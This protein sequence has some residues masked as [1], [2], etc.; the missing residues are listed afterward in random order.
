M[1]QDRHGILLGAG[2]VFAALLCSFA[3]SAHA[4][5]DNQEAPAQ[6]VQ[7]LC[8]Q[9]HALEVAGKCLAG[10]CAGSRVVRVTKPR[11]WN[12]VLDK[13]VDKGVNVSKK[14]RRE[15]LG[16]LQANYPAMSYPLSWERIN[17]F[18]GQ[19]G[20]NVNT[21]REYKGFLYAGFEG[22][23]KIFR[24]A[25]GSNW[26]EVVSTHQD[27]VYGITPFQGILYAG[28]A[29][30]TPQVWRSSD[31]LH[32]QPSAS[33]PS[34]DVGI[35]SVG[36]FKDQL[37]VGTGRSWI[38]RSGDG[39]K[40]EKVAAL[41]GDIHALFSHWV[42]FLVPFNGTLY[43]GLEQGPLYRSEDGLTWVEV[44]S[45]VSDG[46][47]ARGA[48]V[49]N[50]AL[51]V[52]A[53]SGGDIWKTEDGQNWQHVFKVPNDIPGYVASMAVA[54]NYLFASIN[55]YVFRT[56]DGL[57]WEEVGHLASTTLEAMAAWRGTLYVGASI[58]PS[59]Y[60]YRT[61]ITQK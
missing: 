6:A 59:A 41:K 3:P 37:Y 28:A 1:K 56:P 16:F 4:R 18:T 36:V 12:M 52:G 47:G 14:E 58:S 27:T 23:G 42:R 30:P 53:T 24:S 57:A 9:C 35:Y 8:S 10:D 50:G 43:A 61:S 20:W 45:G 33:L 21:L 11:P 5:P 40:W 32:W 39:Q 31:G 49:F 17:A 25:D 29:E 51:Y 2:V 48:M 26:Q 19:G 38:Y 34:E 22:N 15:I 55:G 7:R 46:N 13:M 44:K 60:I 54:G